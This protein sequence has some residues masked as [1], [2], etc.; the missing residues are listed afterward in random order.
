MGLLNVSEKIPEVIGSPSRQRTYCT[1]LKKGVSDCHPCTSVSWHSYLPV[2]PSHLGL[3]Y[4]QH[5]PSLS[6]CIFSCSL[7]RK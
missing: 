5:F 4:P 3:L 1:I 7:E 2:T 6:S